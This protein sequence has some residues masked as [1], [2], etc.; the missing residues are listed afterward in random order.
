MVRQK[1]TGTWVVSGKGTPEPGGQGGTHT[2]LWCY[3][4]FTPCVNWSGSWKDRAGTLTLDDPGG[5]Q[6]GALYQS[7]SRQ[8]ETQG[9]GRGW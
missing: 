4:S 7:G 5:F 2:S 9:W 6:E 8:R 3:I 1:E